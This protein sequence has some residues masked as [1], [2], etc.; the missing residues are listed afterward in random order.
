MWQPSGL[1][2]RFCTQARKQGGVVCLAFWPRIVLALRNCGTL[3]LVPAGTLKD[4]GDLSRFL[5][6]LKGSLLS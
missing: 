3:K 6:F 4:S 5:R 1:C 2:T